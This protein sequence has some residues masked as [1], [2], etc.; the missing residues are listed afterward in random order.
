MPQADSGISGALLIFLL[1]LF[2]WGIRVAVNWKKDWRFAKWPGGQCP[3]CQIQ[4]KQT[5]TLVKCTH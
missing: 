2:V 3:A 5:E 4:S 1:A